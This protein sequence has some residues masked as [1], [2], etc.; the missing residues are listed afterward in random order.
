MRWIRIVPD[1]I[2][3]LL[4]VDSQVEVPDQ[5]NVGQRTILRLVRG[6]R[7]TKPLPYLLAKSRF[8]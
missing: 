8:R 5:K 1:R 4:V 3:M 2:F 6:A 7:H